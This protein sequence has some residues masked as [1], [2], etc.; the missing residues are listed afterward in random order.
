MLTDSAV[1]EE[2]ETI[3]R[4]IVYADASEPARLAVEL[5]D[6]MPADRADS[7]SHVLLDKYH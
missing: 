7:V 4:H 5:L 1:I 2:G 6:S 3:N